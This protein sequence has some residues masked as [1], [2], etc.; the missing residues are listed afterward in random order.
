MAN[1]TFLLQYSPQPDTI[2]TFCQPGFL[3]NEVQHLNQ[4]SGGEFYLLSALH[5]ETKQAEARCSFFMAHTQ[6]ISPI[7]APFGSI[8]F[9][10]ALPD[11]ALDQFILVLTDAA[12]QAGATHLRLVNYPH[13]YAAWQTDR[14]IQALLTYGFT[15]AERNQTFFLPVDNRLFE[16]SIVPAEQRRLRKCRKAN[17]TFAHWQTPVIAEV[18]EFIQNT[19]QQQGYPL[20][21]C[22]DRLTGLLHEFPDQFVVFSVHNGPQLI[23]LTIAVR[24]R[25]DILYN[26]MPASDPAYNSFSP[27]VLLIAGIYGYCQQ[28]KIQLFDLGMAL[29]SNRQLKPGLMRFKRNLGA[30]ESPKFVFEKAL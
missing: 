10:A 23:A 4:Q 11:A 6:A 28:Q 20:T 14:L 16:N 12:R 15:L 13:C 9:T 7:A 25:H 18:V 29:D 1:Y 3:F 8:E 17:F 21:I 19:R 27:M 2:P 22:A 5:Q 26:F 24:V 30:Q